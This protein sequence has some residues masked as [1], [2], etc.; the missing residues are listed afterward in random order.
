MSDQLLDDSS[1]RAQ[2][3]GIGSELHNLS[4]ERQNDEELAEQLQGFAVRLW[5]LAK[6]LPADNELA[7]LQRENERLREAIGEGTTAVSRL[8]S[9][10]EK[11]S[12]VHPNEGDMAREIRDKMNRAL[13]GQDNE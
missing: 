13:K 7:H 9:I 12:F 4:C 1:P 10:S 6:R 5:D 2:A 11:Q 3:L 8:I